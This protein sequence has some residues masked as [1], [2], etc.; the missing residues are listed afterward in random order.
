[1]NE[2]NDG[3]SEY[4]RSIKTVKVERA[5]TEISNISSQVLDMIAVKGK[6]SEPGPTVSECPGR[7]PEEYFKMHHVW[8][9]SNAPHSELQEALPRLRENLPRSGWSV[10]DYG[11]NNSRAKTLVLTADN[12][13]KQYALNIEFWDERQSDGEP[14]LL[15]N[16][17]SACF[18]VPGGLTVDRY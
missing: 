8:S 11:P 12:T 4:A 5:R 18:K 1:M 15:V 2:S 17:V 14:M 3:E 13:E 6:V 9:L 10:V 7:D 16:V